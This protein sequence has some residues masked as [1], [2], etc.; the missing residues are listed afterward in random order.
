M[1]REMSDEQNKTVNK[2]YH[3]ITDFERISD[4]ALNLGEC[5]EELNQKKIEFTEDASRE[6]KVLLLAVEEVLD[7][8]VKAFV[9][10]DMEAA[11][12]IEPLEE[13]IDNL[14]DEIKLRHVDRIAVGKCKYTNG[15]VFNDIL[16]NCERIGD[17]CSNIGIAEK[18]TTHEMAYHDTLSFMELERE[19]GFD[20]KLAQYA[21]K[22]SLN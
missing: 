17:H 4:H 3:A 1:K 7:L 6:L 14:C 9:E 13:T 15:F 22:Y 16:N 18:S 19:H 10:D 20:R 5:A 21:E 8:A 12:S 2:Y 11:Y